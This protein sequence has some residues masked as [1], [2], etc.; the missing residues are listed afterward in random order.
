MT[1][2][3]YYNASTQRVAMLKI[4]EEI[5]NKFNKYYHVLV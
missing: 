5:K 4:M 1:Y 3:L 2:K